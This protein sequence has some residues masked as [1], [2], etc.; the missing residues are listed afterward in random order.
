MTE[1]V[2]FAQTK[3][4]ELTIKKSI[5]TDFEQEAEPESHYDLK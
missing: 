1:N 4:G 5:Q 3:T 2:L